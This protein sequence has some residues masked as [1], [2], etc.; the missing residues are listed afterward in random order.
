M[1]TVFVIENTAGTLSLTVRPGQ[2]DGPGASQRSSDM[3]L[4]GLGTLLWGAGMDTNILRLTET[5]ACPEKAGMPGVPQD[6][7]DLGA[8]RGI[9]VPLNGQ[10]WYNT[11][12][13]V[14]YAYDASS[15]PGIWRPTGG[16]L[17]QT[18]AP[19]SPQEGDLWYDTSESVGSPTNPSCGFS[20]LKV[21][22]PAHPYADTD[23]WVRVPAEYVNKCGD[24]MTGVLIL[25]ETPSSS[26]S[27]LQAATKGYVD[28]HA[29]DSDLH[30][31]DVQNK[32]LD[33][34]TESGSPAGVGSPA[35]CVSTLADAQNLA[36]DI[37]DLFGYS[38]HE[39]VVYE[40]IQSK[41]SLS[42]GTMVGNLTLS[43]PGHSNTPGLAATEN[44]VDAQIAASVPSGVVWPFA[45]PEASIPSGWFICDGS[46]KSET[47][48]AALFAVI[49]TTYN[50]GGETPGYFR[51]PDLRGRSVAGKDNMGGSAAGRITNFSGTT[52]GETGGEENHTLTT[53]EMPAHGHSGGGSGYVGSSCALIRVG[54]SG[55]DTN[56][57]IGCNFASFGGGSAGSGGAH[58]NLQPTMMMNYIIKA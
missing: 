58:N 40:H 8:G 24:T 27:S 52:L 6:E 48:Y 55:A 23:G 42:G 38:S 17:V 7:D 2:L 50:T 44:Y 16:V 3:R 12:T 54:I 22:D 36:T 56:A 41:L 19:T 1:S 39:G 13:K 5:F 43:G 21:Y 15:S 37:C 18:T 30:L 33:S 25:S 9:T 57:P 45:G 49:G 31:T 34:I 26:S 32:L 29:S 47:T 11:T 46:E 53:A 20:I 4:Y 28:I 51:V 14:L 35:P 10:Q